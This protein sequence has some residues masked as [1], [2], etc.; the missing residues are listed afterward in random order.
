MSGP[1]EVRQLAGS[2]DQGPVL[3]PHAADDVHLH[4]ALPRL[5]LQLRLQLP[6]PQHINI[7]ECNFRNEFDDGP[8]VCLHASSSASS[9]LKQ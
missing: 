8:V 4:G 5:L 6:A 1:L 7:I 3:L 2:R 9:S